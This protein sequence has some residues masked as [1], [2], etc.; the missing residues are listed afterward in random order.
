M[1]AIVSH[2][3]LMATKLPWEYC[4]EKFSTFFGGRSI[5]MLKFLFLSYAMKFK[6]LQFLIQ[7]ISLKMWELLLQLSIAFLWLGNVSNKLID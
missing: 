4:F 7:F 2:S 3:L 5:W 6:C 1:C